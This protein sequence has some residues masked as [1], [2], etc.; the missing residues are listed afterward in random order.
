MIPER[1][2]GSPAALTIIGAGALAAA[3]QFLDPSGAAAAPLSQESRHLAPPVTF[4]AGA[5]AGIAEAR[6]DWANLPASTTAGASD[7][8]ALT[9]VEGPRLAIDASAAMCSSEVPDAAPAGSACRTGW[10]ATS[11]AEG[12][13]R[14]EGGGGV[15]ATTIAQ[16][17]APRQPPALLRPCYELRAGAVELL[18]AMP[19]A[20]AL[21]P[22]I[23]AQLR[24]VFGQD[25]PISV[26]RHDDP[27]VIGASPVLFVLVRTGLGG[28][29]AAERLDTF[30]ARWW[31]DAQPTVAGKVEVSVEFA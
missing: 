17:G 30:N 18:S 26:V 9:N 8:S 19:A 16:D 27:E 21:L 1:F 29:Q 22:E 20:A 4:S 23:C 12:E 24:R 31:F 6:P 7:V 28:E 13:V 14:I 3:I 2:A 15:E 11:A 5:G 10:S 25:A